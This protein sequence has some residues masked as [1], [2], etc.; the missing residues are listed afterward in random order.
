MTN[1]G[2]VWAVPPDLYPPGGF[3][4]DTL[5]LVGVDPATFDAIAHNH[6]TLGLNGD[7]IDRVCFEAELLAA[8]AADPILTLT[9]A[10]HLVDEWPAG[11]V[12]PL[13]DACLNLCVPAP[14]DRAWWRLERNPHLRLEMDYCAPA[15]LAHS[16][17]L[18][19]PDTWTDHDRELAL[20]WTLR[21]QATCRCG[22]R[23]DQ[24]ARDPQAF[25]AAY[26]D[27]PGCL[28]LHRAERDIPED[29]RAHVTAYLTPATPDDDPDTDDTDDTDDGDPA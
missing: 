27:C 7:V 8:C 16:R 2:L 3:R 14:V 12:E 11:E 10:R 21:K 17:F 9:Q 19:G 23:R 22:T 24:W 29:Q 15:G 4:T 25:N 18:G 26:T 5:T 28:E 13:L 6:T 1:A 20:A